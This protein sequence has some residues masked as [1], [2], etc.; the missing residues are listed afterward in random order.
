MRQEWTPVE[1]AMTWIL[2]FIQAQLPV[3]FVGGYANVNVL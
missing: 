1:V 2:T 3:S